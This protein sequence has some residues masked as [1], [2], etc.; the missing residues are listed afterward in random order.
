MILTF[1][2]LKINPTDYVEMTYLACHAE[3]VNIACD[4][5]MEKFFNGAI[6]EDYILNPANAF[7]NFITGTI[8]LETVTFPPLH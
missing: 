5:V 1:E 2:E 3:I 7:V 8:D 6:E 4:Y